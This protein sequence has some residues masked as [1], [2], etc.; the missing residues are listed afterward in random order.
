MTTSLPRP[1]AT[2]RAM[3]LELTRGYRTVTSQ[4][5]FR[6][7]A[8]DVVAYRRMRLGR[9][10]SYNLRR[11]I[12]T[13][14]GTT[15]HYRR[16]RGDIQGIR[17][18]WLEGVYSVPFGQQPQVIVDLGA[19]IGLT[20]LFFC[21]HYAPKRIV[22]VEP[23]AANAEVLRSNAAQCRA[24]LDIVV[25]AVGPE[26]GIVLF[27]ESEESNLGR[28]SEKGRPVP[29][30]SMHSLIKTTGLTRIDLLKIDI[31][32]GEGQLLSLAND[33]LDLVG[34]IMIEFHPQAVDE[35]ALIALLQSRGFRYFAHN[36]VRRLGKSDYFQRPEWPGL[37]RLREE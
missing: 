31:E 9:V 21:E 35:R 26:D 5:F 23:D 28:I 24:A 7:F 15:I 2:A 14:G 19:N 30:V 16:N 12:V 29:C 1:L 11:C 6:T 17:E 18:V 34:S 4:S 10:R 20:S 25:A 8:W 3:A 22:L 13:R 37:Q 33:W 36:D 27:S 32:G